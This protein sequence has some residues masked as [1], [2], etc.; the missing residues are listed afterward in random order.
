LSQFPQVIVGAR[1]SKSGNAI[2]RSGDLQAL[3]APLA[4]TTT[5]PVALRIDHRVP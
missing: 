2:A 1:L 3:S 4:V 5:S